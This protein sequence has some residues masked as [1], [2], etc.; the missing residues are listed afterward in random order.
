MT[1]AIGSASNG[2]QLLVANSAIL[3]GTSS[4]AG[5][6]YT[7]PTGTVPEV[8]NS[9]V[10]TKVSG[11]FTPNAVNYVG[12]EYDRIVDDATADQIYIWNPTKKNET[13][14]TAPLAKILRYKIVITT[15]I[16]ALNVL[17]IAKVTTDIANNVVDVTDQRDMLGR[18]G[19]A[20][21]SNPNPSY[22]FPWAAGRQENPTTSTVSTIDPFSGGDKQ[23]ESLKQWMDAI[24][25][26]ILEIKGTVYWYSAN[27]MSVPEGL[28]TIL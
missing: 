22:V 1:G 19:K 2:L 27:V 10:N 11:A 8:L 25:S 18:L 9:T 26:S 21:V 7:V 23:L 28:A 3:H 17:P 14:K 20:G 6:F 4:Q 13:T 15:S 12:I 5:T 16:W 24:M